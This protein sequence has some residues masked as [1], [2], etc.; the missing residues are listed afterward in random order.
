MATDFMQAGVPLLRIGNITP[1]LITMEGCNYVAPEKAERQWRQ[2]RLKLGDIV[3]SASAS[4]G[5][6]RNVSK[7]I[8][9]S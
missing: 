9:E 1:G 2:F 4:T 5:M 8:C 3:I 6:V 7:T